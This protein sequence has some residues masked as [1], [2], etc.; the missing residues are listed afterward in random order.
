[1]LYY[2]INESE[3]HTM[4]NREFA[5]SLIDQIS[6]A[7]L[8]YVIP[9]LQG[10]SLSDEIP[11]AETLEAMEEVQAMIDNG[12]AEHFD[13]ATSDFLDMLLEE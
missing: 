3:V 7:K 13:G 11:N 4:S 5:K 1:M 8:L 6:D 12:K 2:D 10:A 9:Y